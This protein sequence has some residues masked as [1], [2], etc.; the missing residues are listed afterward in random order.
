MIRFIVLFLLCS[1]VYAQTEFIATVNR[2]LDGDTFLINEKSF[3]N[4][5]L[6]VRM[7]GINSPEL[8]GKCV[9]EKDRA[10]VARS[11]LQSILPKGSSI[12]L[13]KVKWDKYGGRINAIVVKDGVVVNDELL[14]SPYFVE[15]G[16]K[17]DW[18]K[19]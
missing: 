17:K 11:E 12:T 3:G 1:S 4:L 18:C 16:I 15:Y 13:Q 6:K 19:Q 10:K 9:L 14:K 2:V 8:R 5:S 7:T